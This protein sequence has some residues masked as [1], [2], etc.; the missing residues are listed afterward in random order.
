MC[1]VSVFFFLHGW[2]IPVFE[3]RKYSTVGHW[4]ESSRLC[5][6]CVHSLSIDIIQV[7]ILRH[8]LRENETVE[9]EL[10]YCKDRTRLRLLGKETCAVVES[11]TYLLHLQTWNREP[12]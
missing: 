12:S 6:L 3:Q 4:E 5:H 9:K 10:G 8:E 2:M 11:L 7:C 1:S